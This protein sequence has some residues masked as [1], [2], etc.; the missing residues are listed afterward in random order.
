M[1]KFSAHGPSAPAVSAA[2]ADE[3]KSPAAPTPF[4]S[5]PDSTVLK[6]AV[7]LVFLVV[8]Y[9][10]SAWD[11]RTTGAKHWLGVRKPAAPTLRGAGE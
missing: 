2:I 7:R 1:S 8:R 10:L 5:A 3:L 9:S 6:R 4:V 11:A